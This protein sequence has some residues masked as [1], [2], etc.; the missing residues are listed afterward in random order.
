MQAAT[1]GTPQT[2]PGMPAKTPTVSQMRNSGRRGRC[3]RSGFEEAFEDCRDLCAGGL[4]LWLE[5]VVGD[6]C[7]EAFCYCP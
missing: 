6:A 5:L 2:A 3:L 4:S 7:E 1:A